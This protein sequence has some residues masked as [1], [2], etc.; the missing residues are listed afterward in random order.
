VGAGA[1]LLR[2]RVPA[3]PSPGSATCS[4]EGQEVPSPPTPEGKNAGSPCLSCSSLFCLVF[5]PGR[6]KQNRAVVGGKGGKR[7]ENV[8]VIIDCMRNKPYAGAVLKR[9]LSSLLLKPKRL[10]GC[11]FRIK[12]NYFNITN[13]RNNSSKC[14]VETGALQI[15]HVK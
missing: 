5:P 4:S 12:S 8:S 11:L 3:A 2:Q 1:L 10:S 9:G 13:K 14:V 6:R 7:G 15:K